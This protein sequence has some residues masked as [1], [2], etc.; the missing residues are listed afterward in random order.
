MTALVVVRTDVGSWCPHRVRPVLSHPA[1][2]TWHAE[3][4]LRQ[5]GG[6]IDTRQ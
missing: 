1:G 4:V 5:H 3:S 6:K 2:R